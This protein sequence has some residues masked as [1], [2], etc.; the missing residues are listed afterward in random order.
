VPRDTRLPVNAIVDNFH[1]G[2]DVAEIA[3]QFEVEPELVEA[4]LTYAVVT[5]WQSVDLSSAA[6]AANP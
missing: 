1:Y 4:V 3:E 5:R 6:A 2:V